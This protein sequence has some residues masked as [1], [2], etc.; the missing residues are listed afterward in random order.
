MRSLL[1]G[2][3]KEEEDALLEEEEAKARSL[4]KNKTEAALKT[5]E[6][7]KLAKKEKK[8]KSKKSNRGTCT[9]LINYS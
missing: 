7:I 1:K 4:K 9:D 3:N 8:G 5:T 6:D 2:L